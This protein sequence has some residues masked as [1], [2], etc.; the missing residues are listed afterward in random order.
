MIRPA[1]AIEQRALQEVADARRA[2]PRDEEEARFFAG[3]RTRHEPEAPVAPLAER[4]R[5][6]LVPWSDEELAAAREPWPHAFQERETGLF[7]AG[8]V[9]ILAAAGREGKTTVTIGA[10]VALVIGHSLA[11]MLPAAGRSV[12]VYSAEDDRAQYARKVAAQLSL[13]GQR[14]AN[15]V[16]HR[17]LVPDLDQIGNAAARTLVTVLDGQPI[18]SSTV[19]AIIEAVR[20]LL[21]SEVPPGLLV[22]ETASTLSDAEENNAG[23][24]VLVLALRQIAR[25]LNLP[26]VLSHHVSQASLAG[27]PD[28]NLATSD[29]RG[30][31]ALV[32][33]ARQTALLVNLGSEDDPFPDTDARTILRR[34]VANGRPERLT[35]LVS[36]D[37]SKGTTPPPIFFRWIATDWGPAAVELDP[38]LELV[39]RSLRKVVEMVR[40]ERAEVRAEAKEWR[41][42]AAAEAQVQRLVDAVERLQRCSPGTPITARRL[43]EELGV[44]GKAISD[45]LTNACS[46]GLLRGTPIT[47]RGNPTTA[48][49]LVGRGTEE[50]RA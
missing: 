25:A 8:E 6:R 13:L 48:Y 44:A 23:F 20:P 22:F 46:R 32:N 4:L 24:R 18:P 36:L 14:D 28:L 39:G 45:L 41:A 34:M 37:S 3:A 35:A 50:S 38:P 12:I 33:N 11:G 26:V 29:I 1:P 31:T 40:A 15:T 10:A 43:R 27:L 7:P 9:S 5:A 17:L 30:G 21:D 16:Q 42:G 2:D 47:H 19:G 49:Q